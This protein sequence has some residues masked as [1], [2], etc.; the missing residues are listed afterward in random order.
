M[1]PDQIQRLQE[2]SEQLADRFLLE[3]DPTMWP[4]TPG[5]PPAEWT[6]KQR[7]DAWWC[8]KNA[9][10]TGG[11]LKFTLDVLSKHT[12]DDAPKDPAAE[13][14]LE[15]QVKEAERRSAKLVA[16]ALERA[17]RKPEFDARTH[18]KR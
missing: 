12:G 10:G 16:D 5:T 17:K 2:L 7:G 8:K 1:R 15:R 18:G 6:D 4:G 11:V 9:M 3:A 13:G 14:D